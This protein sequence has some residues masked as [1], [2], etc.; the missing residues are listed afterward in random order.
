MKKIVTIMFFLCV[1][2]GFLTPM[3]LGDVWWHLSTGQWIMENMALPGQDPFNIAPD[4]SR[5]QSL[6]LKGFWLSQIIFHLV[7]R[8]SGLIGLISF[9]S[10]LFTMAVFVMWKGARQQGASF[11]LAYVS[12]IPA[13]LVF[14]FYDEARP[15]T[16]SILFTAIALLVLER[17][18]EPGSRF[19]FGE[20]DMK[21]EDHE[22]GGK[23][24]FLI[25][26]P[27]MPLWANM[28]PGFVIGLGFILFY[29]GEHVYVS[30]TNKGVGIN[31]PFIMVCAAAV[32]LSALNPNG[33]EAL[34]STISMLSRS[35]H[36]TVTIH[37][38]LGMSQF[39]ARTGEPSLLVLFAALAAGGLASFA[40]KRQSLDLLHV[41]MFLSL[42]G[43]SLVTFRAGLFFAIASAHIIGYNLSGMS[44]PG[45]KENLLEP[46]GDSATSTY[47]MG[48]VV[49]I[50]LLVACAALVST[51]SF[52]AKGTMS[53]GIF[54]DKAAS[55][56]E[57]TSAPSNLYHP[58]EWGGYLIWRLYPRY[59]TFVDGRALIPLSEHFEVQNAG[60]RWAEILQSNKVSTVLFW[61]ILPLGKRVPPIVFALA[62]S[63]GWRAV[64]WDTRSL[65]FVRT[66]HARAPLGRNAVWELLQ[67]L[68]LQGISI[69]PSD[70]EN[71]IAM[72]E[73]FAHRGL[74][75]Q[76]RE[77]FSKA[78]SLDPSNR[79]AAQWLR[80]P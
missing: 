75:M 58:Y 40:L 18:R 8:L 43:L 23:P 53:P 69:D 55:F 46:S 31:R 21:R 27:L 7:E 33:Y 65:V 39:V 57:S 36:G 62:R 50:C 59:K 47:K 71:Y 20:K 32:A 10:A 29:A 64:Y 38:H 54:P 14:T 19:R 76:A 2:A 73:I 4:L 51:R 17:A 24:W 11:A 52:L 3:E 61:P 66:E 60:D 25:L 79:V 70:A 16:F 56:I 80:L 44:I 45:I 12:V 35:A 49:V 63:S 26:V 6:T 48:S 77:A 67:S 78:L 41:L 15:Q 37:E 30:I 13:I 68:V 42:A 34:S 1:S 28:H 74:P 5:D 9:K 72:G 22:H